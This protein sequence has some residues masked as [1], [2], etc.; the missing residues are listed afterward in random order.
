MKNSI[1]IS[2]YLQS[3]SQKNKEILEKGIKSNISYV[4]TSLNI[5]EKSDVD[6][7]AELLELLNLCN[8]HN[9]L[10]FADVGPQAL[11]NIGVQSYKELSALGLKAI[12][13]D[14]GFD[15][16]EMKELSEMMHLIINASTFTQKDYD[17][18]IKLDMN[19]DKI[20]AC[21]NYYPK[22]YTGLDEVFIKDLNQQY[23]N[24]NIKTMMF[25]CGDEKRAPLFEGLPTVEDH[26]TTDFLTSVLECRYDLNSDIVMI[27]DI[28][29][30]DEHW[31]EF[32][33]FHEG[34]IPIRCSLEAMYK[35]YY[36]KRFHDRRDSSPYLIRIVES[37][38][39]PYKQNDIVM[40]NCID[41]KAGSICISNQ[42]YGRYCGEVE[43]TRVDLPQDHRVN[44]IGKVGFSS[45]PHLPYIR[46][47]QAFTLLPNEVE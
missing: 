6:V 45:L 15:Y 11:K 43:I 31:K 3:G 23:A 41:R 14:D 17:E 46:Y 5:P 47:G 38:R 24:W 2:L 10:L 33:Y 40:D 29:I 36:D 9:I 34:V 4:F 19:F 39:K 13:L 30:N 16:E 20:I 18:L 25:V 27:G 7:K 26:R 42:E 1:G 21:H 44:V 35:N 12:R 32:N 22:P 28:N 8:Q 37:R